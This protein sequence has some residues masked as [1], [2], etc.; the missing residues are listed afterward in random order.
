MWGELVSRQL[1]RYTGEDVV[2]IIPTKDRPECLRKLLESIKCQQVLCSKLIIVDSGRSVADVA[3][4]YSDEIPIEYL[5]S[6]K[7]GQLVQKRIGVSHLGGLCRLV[8]FLDDD[9]VIEDHALEEM[10]RFWNRCEENVAGV[11]FNIVNFKPYKH[12]W[13]GAIFGMSS[14]KLGRVLRSSYNV[15]TI[16]VVKDLRAQ[17]LCGGAT[18]WRRDI[19]EKYEFNAIEF[20]E[21][22]QKLSGHIVQLK[23]S[24]FLNSKFSL[25]S[26]AQYNSA[27]DKIITNIRFRYNP[28]EGHDLYIVYDEGLNTY[29]EREIP[30]L[31][32]TSVRTI[33]M[34]YSYTFRIGG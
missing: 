31:P 33:L 28:R 9:M 26:L 10:L 6:G 27:I 29:R 18:L 12:S 1:N 2:L 13:I 7:S 22:N 21:R 19:V 24:A 16:P 14:K 15:P 30:I 34:K 3:K 20:P 25:V 11:S 17:W 4:N 23:I 5:R 32:R 8:G